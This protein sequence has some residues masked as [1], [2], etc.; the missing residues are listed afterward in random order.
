MDVILLETKEG[1]TLLCD[2][3]SQS[4]MAQLLRQKSRI[5]TMNGYG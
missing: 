1:M 2:I 5:F 4:I 3:M